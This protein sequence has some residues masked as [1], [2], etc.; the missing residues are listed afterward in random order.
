VRVPDPAPA[1]LANGG[2]GIVSEIGVEGLSRLEERIS[3]LSEHEAT[4]ARL[5]LEEI[6]RA[7]GEAR[8]KG[9][10]LVVRD[11]AEIL[12]KMRGKNTAYIGT[13]MFNP[14]STPS[15]GTYNFSLGLF[16]PDLDNAY[17]WSYVC[18]CVGP[19]VLPTDV[20]EALAVRDLRFPTLTMPD[21]PG[22][23]LQPNI[24]Y[25][26]NVSLKIPKDIDPGNYM[27]NAFLFM[28]MFWGA[29]L[30]MDRFHFPIKVS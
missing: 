28:N 1:A 14:A 25:T 19:A 21:Y 16:N 30:Y 4:H 24:L 20:G 22:I 26:L 2:E 10:V 8:E 13:A 9:W 15:P 5:V 23:N 27:V 3:E 11:T 6:E 7:R 17:I 12:E 29:A 18:V